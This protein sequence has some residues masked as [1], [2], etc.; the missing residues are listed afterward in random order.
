MPTEVRFRRGTTAQNDVFTGGAGELSVDNEK[1]TLRVH[2]GAIAGGYELVNLNAVQTISNKTIGSDLL[3]SVDSAYDLGSP[4]AKW[5]DLYLSGSTIFL[6]NITLKD[7]GGVLAVTDSNGVAVSVSLQD[8]STDDLAEGSN[9]LYYTKVRVDS[10]VTAGISALIDGAPDALNTLNELAAALND[11]SDFASTVTNSLSTKLAIDNFDSYFDTALLAKTTNDLTEGNNLY[12]TQL[13][14]DSAFTDKSTTNLTEG[15]NLYYTTTRA[16]SDFDAR[17][18]TKSTDNLIEGDNLYYTR[19]RFDSA[20]GDATSTA[21]IRSYFS[22]SGDLSYDSATGQFSFDVEN[23]YTKTNFDSDFNV[24]LDEAALGGTGLTFDSATN[25]LSITNTGVVAGNYGS[26]TLVPVISVN[27]QGQIDSIGEVVVDGI[28]SVDFDSV[29]GTFSINTAN[30]QTFSDVITLDPY[31]TSDLTEGSNLYYTRDRFDSALGD[32]TST[33]TIRSYFSASGDISYNSGN[34]TFTVDTYKDSDFDARLATKTTDNLTEG[35]NLYYTTARADSDAK[36]A[37]SAGTG[38]SYSSATGVFSVPASGVIAGT[39]GSG[40]SVPQITVDAQGFVDSIGEVTIAGVTGVNFDSSNGTITVQTTGGNFS[41]VIT[42]DPYTTDDLAEG[43]NLYYTTS[44]ADSDFDARLTIKSTSDLIEGSN[45]YYTSNRADSD[46]RHAISVTDAG[47]DGSLT[48]SAATGEITYTGPSASEVRTHFS[49][50]TGVTLSSGQ[51]SIGQSVG[52][53]DSVT[54]AEISVARITD[55]VAPIA[56][57]DAASKAY[58]D[59]V[60]EGL[61]ARPSVRAATTGNLDAF[62][63]SDGGNPNVGYGALIANADG[64]LPNIDSVGSWEL[65]DGILVKSQTDARYNGRYVVTVLGNDSNPWELTRC[66]LCDSSDEVAGS[67]MFVTEG[68]LYA[69]TGWVLSVADL[70]TFTIN[71]DDITVIQFSGAGSYTAGTNLELDGTEFNLSDNITLTSVTAD[72]LAGVYLGF[73]SDFGDQT[74]DDLTQGSTNKYFSNALARSAFSVTGNLTYDSATGVFGATIPEGYNSTNFDSDFDDKTT[75]DLTEGTNQ[76]FTQARAR[77]SVSVTDAGGDGSLTYSSGTGVF[78]YTGPSAAEVRAHFSEGTAIDISSGQISVDLSEL[79][80]STS[81]GDGDFFVV[82]D[83]ANAQKKLTKGNINI[84]GFN[85]DAG[86]STTTGTVTS[87]AVTAGT[88]LSGGGTITASGT[89]SL[90]LDFAELT[91][92]TGDIAGTTE[93]IVQNGTTE[94]RKAASEIKLSN[95]NNDAG[96]TTNTGTVTSVAVTAGTGLSGGGTVTSSGTINLDVDLS[97]LT[98]STTNGD[99]DY[100]VVVDTSDVTRKLT[101]ANISLSEFNNNSGWTSNTGTVTSVAVA[102]GNGLTGGAT[103]TTSGTATL[104]VGAGSY[105][106]VAA[107]TVSVDATSANTASKVVAR[108]GSGNFSAGTITA[109][110]TGNASTATALQNARTIGGV[111]F[112]GTA[113]I[114]LPG[115]N[116]T[117][118]QNT[119]GSA[120]TLTTARTINDTSFNG[121]AN[122]TVEPYVERDDTTNAARYI[123]FVDD[124]TAAFK[125]LNMDTN[126]SYNPST[127][128]LATSISGS[129]ASTTGNAATATALQNARTIGGVSFNGTA[130]INLPGVNTAGNQNTTGSAATL[131]TGRTIALS[132]DVTATGVSFNGSADISL[133]TQIAANVVGANELNVS[134]NG[135]NGQL[136]QSDGDGSFTWITP[137]GGGATVATKSDNVNYNVIFTNETTG[138]QANAYINATNLYFNP[139]TGTLNATDFNSL[140]DINYKENVETIESGLD[141]ISKINPVSFNWKDNGNKAYGV[142]AQELES[143]LPELV[144]TS[145]E[146]KKSVSYMQMIAFL[147]KA[148]Q[149]QQEE[150]E[151]LKSKIS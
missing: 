81:D 132:G 97:E 15:N 151:A 19:N 134:G 47:G 48:Y 2:D 95:F 89:I 150:I 3:P 77:G 51:I 49:A 129:S 20:L 131:T 41:D 24:A 29:N 99:G 37:V 125:R 118:N 32:A 120:A 22:A 62:Y 42:L 45:L 69:N 70:A 73:D 111:S 14:F 94:S 109:A 91:D 130:N 56:S 107:D 116:A 40:T 9:N 92:M 98:T 67:Y 85:N 140:S 68:A 1:Y 113:N 35:S 78:T 7:S 31:S 71:E 135:T 75:T 101:K 96:W 86:Y 16:D 124:A 121:S 147:I 72:T 104:N 36:N 8:N 52:T 108:D 115:V 141:V 17:L 127:N 139:S 142:I 66:G 39:Y 106:T 87:I 4:S 90:A 83:A 102:A 59:E 145:E 138:T 80:T 33:A 74:T 10:D 114:N 5:K 23:V 123:T 110:L 122:I 100:F 53:T 58:V 43:D 76:Y 55:L 18:A 63:D 27:N 137:S 21:T 112:N 64:L 25:T 57:T 143:I 146:G 144:N 28:T 12:Y 149:E 38:L 79:T 65:F 88:G 133:S 54:F 82:V 128:V 13:R 60:A 103:I 61:L 84:S 119:T 30:G 46:A 44:R 136:L 6:G 93:F 117:G 105:I 126:L 148:V 34:G 50:G 11:D 26:A